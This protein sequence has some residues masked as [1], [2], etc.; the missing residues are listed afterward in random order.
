MLLIFKKYKFTLSLNIS[1]FKRNNIHKDEIFTECSLKPRIIWYWSHCTCILNH[2]YKLWNFAVLNIGRFL[3][4]SRRCLFTLLTGV[5]QD[6]RCGNIPWICY[7]NPPHFAACTKI[8]SS[9]M[10]RNTNFWRRLPVLSLKVVRRGLRTELCKVVGAS[11]KDS[12]HS[13]I[14]LS[15]ELFGR[16]GGGKY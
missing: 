14:F 7:N 5:Q 16:G 8:G 10:R 11:E 9:C 13:F 12:N 4:A 3:F 6:H 1:Y 15:A 2:S